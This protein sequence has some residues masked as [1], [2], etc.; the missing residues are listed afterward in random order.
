MGFKKELKLFTILPDVL[1]LKAWAFPYLGKK[2]SY[3]YSA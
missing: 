1:A 2:Y 3:A